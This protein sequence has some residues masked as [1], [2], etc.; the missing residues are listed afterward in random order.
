MA[1]LPEFVRRRVLFQ[2]EVLRALLRRLAHAAE[3][4]LRGE[5]AEQDLRDAERTLHDVLEV[6]V[7]QEEATLA[8]LLRARW[9]PERLARLHANHCTALD[10]LQM[11]RTRA[12]NESATAS[13]R[14]VLRMLAAM[15]AE[16]RDLLGVGVEQGASRAEQFDVPPGF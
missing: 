10:A 1:Q 9:D 2:H 16:E 6:H 14:L 7:R 13:Q 11:Q 8:P 3:R 4:T 12:P 15:A 5:P